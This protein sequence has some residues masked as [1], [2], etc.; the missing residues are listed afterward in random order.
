M[1]RTASAKG[2]PAAP[3]FRPRSPL[4]NFRTPF[5]SASQKL[6]T[7]LFD[8]L[9]AC[10]HSTPKSIVFSDSRQE[11]A[12]LAL[13]IE[14]E[15]HQDVLRHLILQLLH[16]HNASMA[17]IDRDTVTERMN[18]ASAQGDYALVIEL[19]TLLNQQSQLHERC[20]P[21]SIILEPTSTS[22]SGKPLHELLRALVQLGVH[23]WDPAGIA[24]HKGLAWHE[25]LVRHE[26]GLCWLDGAD[27][28]DYGPLQDRIR[29]AQKEL[30]VDTLFARNFYALE[31]TGL[32]WVALDKNFVPNPGEEDG[33]P[34]DA[35]VRVLAE[36][37]RVRE[38][39]LA[40]DDERK[41]YCSVEDIANSSRVYKYAEAVCPLAPRNELKRMLDTLKK[42]KHRDGLL[43]LDF[44]HIWM[45]RPTDPYYSCPVCGR[46]HLHRGAGI[47]TRCFFPLPKTATGVVQTLREQHFLARKITRS[48]QGKAFRLHCEELT[49]QTSDPAERL[50]KFKGIFIDTDQNTDSS[51]ERLAEE[52]DL[53]SVTTTMEVGIDIGPLQ[54]IY[55]ANMPPQRF[56]Y[57][58]RAGRAG[59]RGQACALV[60]T[61]C[62]NRS[63]D[64]HYF[65]HPER[66]VS[67]NPPPPFLT[68]T[69][70]PIWQRLLLKGWLTAAFDLYRT[71][72]TRQ[73]KQCACDSLSM[74]DTHGD[75]PATEDF[76]TAQW[77]Q[78]LRQLLEQTIEVRDQL[79][80]CL[81]DDTPLRKDILQWSSVENILHHIAALKHEGRY[82]S[83]PLGQF[84]AEN[85]L[86]PLYG[87][88]TNV[89]SLYVGIA[90]DAQGKDG[91]ITLERD[92]DLAIYEYAPDQMVAFDKK[93]FRCRGFS[94]PM[95]PPVRA[96][97][98]RSLGTWNAQQR[99]VASCPN[100]ATYTTSPQ[101]ER[102]KCACGCILKEHTYVPYYSPAAFL[103][104]FRPVPQSEETVKAYA[105][106][107]TITLE[108]HPAER[109]S[110]AN[111]SL[112]L[113]KDAGHSF[114]LRLNDGPVHYE[115]NQP[116]AR[117]FSMMQPEAAQYLFSKGD[118]D[119]QATTWKAERLCVNDVLG[120]PCPVRLFSRKKTYALFLELSEN[121]KGLSLSMRAADA[122]KPHY[123]ALRAAAIS[124]TQI[125]AQ[126]AALELDI[127]PE[128][129]EI[130]PPS[131][132]RGL[133]TL[134]LADKL[135]NGAGYCHRLAN[136]KDAHGEP[137]IVTLIR[138][139][140]DP[141]HSGD[142]LMKPASSQSCCHAACYQ[143]LQRY[144]NRMY[145]GLLDWRLGISFLRLL[146]DKDW[147]AGL[148]GDFTAYEMSG[149]L[150]HAFALAQNLC[151]LQPDIYS[152]QR[153]SLK[154]NYAHAL[155]IPCLIH[156]TAGGG[157]GKRVALV[158]PFWNVEEILP[159]GVEGF[160]TFEALRRPLSF[161]R[162]RTF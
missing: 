17:A 80:A 115:H 155:N 1:P 106:S 84:L 111:T 104:D 2:K 43:Q 44:L 105:I 20:V 92:A 34:D 26:E 79:L 96:N 154:T 120:N 138:S 150:E 29:N 27:R 97:T 56:N 148:D 133:P 37:Y 36:A 107:R 98:A 90:R 8:L 39:R 61:L 24:R 103:A 94:P 86:L 60:L 33:R 4:R 137:L 82:S 123:T 40:K 117:S 152:V 49:G 116:I 9:H 151:A 153:L 72:C 31:E 119:G 14:K 145:H 158:H 99:F 108:H 74:P 88:P 93:M 135:V 12:R 68:T 64:L 71:Q 62:R 32:G 127:D 101:P 63:H 126:R 141:Q 124:A 23:P 11:A 48:A 73:K 47:C 45:T 75:F 21:L 100:C 46:T 19:A 142:P 83:L 136:A 122:K 57:Q 143:C 89:R 81:V 58:Q 159:P 114:I 146:L 55:Q 53:L 65:R 118:N 110:I 51:L 30:M 22:D 125:L 52:I 77:L 54:S 112:V 50:R 85:G 78:D 13:N 121:R 156:N 7:E 132:E 41:I 160:T 157:V 162:F 95:L 42:H 38:H 18:Q 87:M 70:K 67:A 134:Q 25:V 3:P 5:V 16:T 140:L 35:W 109:E 147:I 139:L 128:E 6:A 28:G 91:F 59:R 130:L 66:M 161:L 131:F 129:F 149:W 76:F 102:K 113:G 69:H 10:G 144:G 15:H